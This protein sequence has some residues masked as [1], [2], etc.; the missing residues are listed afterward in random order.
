MCGIYAGT[1]P[2]EYEPVTRSLRLHGAVTSVRL[3]ARFWAI[4]DEMADNEDVTTPRF[5]AKL[6][7]E[8]VEL[9]G[10]ARNFTSLLRVVCAVYLGGRRGRAEA[11]ERPGAVDHRPE[12]VRARA[13]ALA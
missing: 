13:A 10:E 6:H 12:V 7:D 8:V 3:E 2:K 11:A 1:D 4:L 5:L 9:H